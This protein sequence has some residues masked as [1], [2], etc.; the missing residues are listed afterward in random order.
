MWD[1]RGL[2]VVFDGRSLAAVKIAAVATEPVEVA[3]VLAAVGAEAGEV[4]VVAAAA[5]TAVVGRKSLPMKLR[6]E[7]EPPA[8]V[9]EEP[10]EEAAELV[11]RIARLVVAQVEEVLLEREVREQQQVLALVRH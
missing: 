9:A 11:E 3:E 4:V 5:V 10:V 8:R 1:A 6:L 7:Q 2:I